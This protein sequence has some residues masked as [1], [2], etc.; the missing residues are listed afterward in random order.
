[1]LSLIA[2]ARVAAQTGEVPIAAAIIGPDGIA[3]ATYHNEVEQR[4]DATAHAELLAIQMACRKLGRKYLEEYTLMVTLEPC[5]M[6]AQA[7]AH[8]KLGK[9][10]YGAYDA[11]SGGV[12]HGA[13]I[14]TQPTCHHAPEIIGGV[15][16]QA[17]GQL[18]TDFFKAKR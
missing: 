10:I 18:L 2:I 15:E 16:A 6:C 5:A 1:M 3:V 7:A 14:F 4:R 17:C 11:K 9:I 13:R 12:E 8:V